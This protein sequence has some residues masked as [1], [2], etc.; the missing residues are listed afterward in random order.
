[1]PAKKQSKS[2]VKQV[3][4]FG[5]VGILNTIVDFVLLNI[6]VITILPKSLELATLNFGS[7]KYVITGLIVAGLISGTVAMI[8]SYIFNMRFTFKVK[9]IDAKHTVYFFLVTIFGLYIIRPIILKI[10]TDTWMWP[11]QVAYQVTQVLHLP[12]SQDFDERNLA[13]L[14]AISIVLVYNY[15][16]YKFFVFPHEKN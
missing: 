5:L 12:L 8:N 6:L 2:E 14:V 3:G 10:F 15:L 4:R 13:L 7:I 1:M 11:S 16:M 9:K